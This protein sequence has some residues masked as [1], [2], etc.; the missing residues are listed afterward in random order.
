LKHISDNFYKTDSRQARRPTILLKDRVKMKIKI[1][2]FMH[3]RSG[4]VGAQADY[5]ALPGIC[6]R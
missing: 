3:H 1:D 2:E 6:N 4:D 5:F